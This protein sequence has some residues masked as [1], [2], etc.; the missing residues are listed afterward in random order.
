[1]AE[2][3]DEGRVGDDIGGAPAPRHP[4]HHPVGGIQP[5]EVASVHLHE[6]GVRRQVGGHPRVEHFLEHLLGVRGAPGGGEGAHSGGVA[7]HVGAAR[8]LPHAAEEAED[9]ADV[10]GVGEGAHE[11]VVVVLV[12]IRGFGGRI[13]ES[14]CGGGG[15]G[16]DGGVAA[17]Q[18][19]GAATEGNG[20]VKEEP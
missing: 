11:A 17:E 5:L 19:A 7:L 6:K 12:Q 9:A 1:M 4:S 3:S 2:P 14:S 16:G 8:G 18:A 20:A 10:A 13:S 15:G